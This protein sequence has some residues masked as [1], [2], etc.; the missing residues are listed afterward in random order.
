MATSLQEHIQCQETPTEINENECHGK[1]PIFCEPCQ[2]DD[3]FVEA[4]GFCVTCSEYLCQ[5]CCRDHKRN[6][7]TREHSLLKN[8]DIPVD[9]TP[10]TTIK[11]LSTCET[12]PDNDIA[13]ECGDHEVFVCVFCLTETHRKCENVHD[14]GAVDSFD[15]DINIMAELQDR[16]QALQS[17]KEKQRKTIEI[18]QQEVKTN[19]QSL[20]EKWKDHITGLGND[21]ET[22]LSEMSISETKKLIEHIN[23]CQEIQTEIN[24]NKS[25]IDTLMNHGTKRQISV[26]LSRTTHARANLKE[27]LQTLERQRQQSIVLMNVKELYLL[28]AIAELSIEEE[29]KNELD[30]LEHTSDEVLVTLH[31]ENEPR[32]TIDKSIQ[33]SFDAANCDANKRSPKTPKKID[34]FIQASFDAPNPGANKKLPKTPK[35]IDKSIQT[36]SYVAIPDAKQRSSKRFLER[37]I[38]QKI[39]IFNVKTE[40]DVYTCSI[41]AV[42]LTEYGVLVA[43]YGNSKLKLINRKFELICEHSL[44]G[45]PVDMCCDGENCYVCYSDL[46]KVTALCINKTS[47]WSCYEYY[48]KYQ[49]LSLTVFDS[50]LMILF[51]CDE[52]FDNTE[53]DDVHIE[54]RKGSSINVF[55]YKPYNNGFKEIKEAKRIFLF[56][57]SSIVLSENTRVSCYTVD[58]ETEELPD[59]KWF[60]KSY[61]QNVLEKAKGVAKD[62]E[63]N[64]YICGEDSNNVH[65]ASSAN[66]RRNR[67]IVQNINSPMCVALDDQKDRLII[68]C[69]DDNYLHVYSFK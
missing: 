57:A 22:Q 51:A 28:T 10:F 44:P 4:T 31:S 63:G 23:G 64:V 40:T 12:H 36:V 60:Y 21:L 39:A 20:E 11:Q 59:R 5:T 42:Y 46:K 1:K 29:G 14:L 45:Q 24:R 6:K 66:Y 65:Q 16:I 27:K 50:R 37:Q 62:S 17:Q 3:S 67:V 32:E 2:Y 30:V 25:L 35:K 26:V 33:T 56:D 8:D 13:Y 61:Q 52:N 58:T 49:P 9:K 53:A 69:R 34:K 43:D 38:G 41:F 55:I 15:S 48:T 68:G 54:I 47:I 19:I 18:E 7:V